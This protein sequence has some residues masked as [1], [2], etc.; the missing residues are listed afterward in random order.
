MNLSETNRN[1][2][3]VKFMDLQLRH[4]AAQEPEPV[5]TG[6]SK[7]TQI[8]AIY[9]KGG[10][11]KSFTLAN[12]SYMMAQQG[13]K[14]LLIGCDPKSDTTS[15]LFGGRACPTIIETSSK[16]KLAGEQVAIGDVCFKRDGVFAMELGGPEV[17]RGCGGRG[18]IHGFEL[19]EKLGFHEWGFDY[20]LLDFLGDVVCGGFGLPIARD[21]C[22]KV[23]VVA[24]NDLQSLYVANN[25][26]S[27]VEYFRKLGGNVGVAGMVI[28]K[29]DGTGEAAAFAE[30]VGIPVLS[31]IPAHDDI[32][33]K[34]ASYEIIGRPGTQWGP[35]F[36]TLA[37]NVALAP[38][39]RPAPL[40]QDAL[41]GLFAAETVGR[42][43]TLEPATTFDMCG[44]SETT[45]AS[46]EVIY[47]AA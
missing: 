30:R 15:L 10:I 43:V 40:N 4:E 42:N 28:N 24:S 18:I 7:E 27:A 2:A 47:D 21:M 14:V 35:L 13:K 20:V 37:A 29:D 25:V 41:L 16:K 22:Q 34:S 9:G 17:G 39:V 45:R 46:L 5:A 11:G 1:G 38:P 26:C 8:I 19:L 23:I 12:L 31:A 44:K 32:R 33:R 3:V 36:E 6:S